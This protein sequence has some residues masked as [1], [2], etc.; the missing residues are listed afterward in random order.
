MNEEAI[1]IVRDIIAEKLID[2]DSKEVQV[3]SVIETDR[4]EPQVT[5]NLSL[6]IDDEHKGSLSTRANALA[7]RVVNVL[8]LQKAETKPLEKV[9]DGVWVMPLLADFVAS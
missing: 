9:S 4:D 8:G 5:I 1:K 3:V 6:T 7:F 2:F